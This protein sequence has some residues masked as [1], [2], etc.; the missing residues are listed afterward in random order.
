MPDPYK[1]RLYQRNRRLV[2]QASGFTCYK[3]G[4][5]ANTADHILPLA[6]GGSHDL[7]NLRACCLRCNSAGGAELMNRTRARRRI[8]RPSRRW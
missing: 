8:G 7:A 2:L 3:C 4:R 6:L 5:P 1:S